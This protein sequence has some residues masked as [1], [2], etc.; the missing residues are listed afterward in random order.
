MISVYRLF[1]LVFLCVLFL[2]GYIYTFFVFLLS[3]QLL[4]MFLFWLFLFCYTPT[5]FYCTMWI[6]SVS[7]VRHNWD[8]HGLKYLNSFSRWCRIVVAIYTVGMFDIKLIVMWNYGENEKFVKLIKHEVKF[9]LVYN[10]MLST[11]HFCNDFM[12]LSVSRVA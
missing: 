6:K 9:W 1:C 11:I 2:F 10:W 5:T 12:K 7:A 4:Y 3:L 8:V